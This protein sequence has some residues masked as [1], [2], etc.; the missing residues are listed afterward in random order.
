LGEFEPCVL[1]RRAHAIAA[2]LDLGLGKSDEIECGEAACQMHFDR[3][4]RRMDA[5]QSTGID[6]GDGHQKIVRRLLLLRQV[7]MATNFV[8]TH[9]IADH[10]AERT[11]LGSW[12]IDEGLLTTMK[13]ATILETV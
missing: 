4:E 10:S 13:R 7:V 1:Q 8:V 11:R 12:N 5:E 6:D 9:A 2:L 3:D